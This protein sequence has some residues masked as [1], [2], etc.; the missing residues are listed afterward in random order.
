MELQET[1]IGV[2]PHSSGMPCPVCMY[3][4]AYHM[5]VCIHMPMC[6]SIFA[7]M[8]IAS[9]GVPAYPA[10]SSTRSV[11][12]FCQLRY[13]WNRW[14]TPLGDKGRAWLAKHCDDQTATAVPRVHPAGAFPVAWN[15]GGV[16]PFP[17]PLPPPESHPFP[18]AWGV[19]PHAM[20]HMGIVIRPPLFE[21]TSLVP[22]PP[23]YP[24]WERPNVTQARQIAMNFQNMQE[25]F[26]AMN[27]RMDVIATADSRPTS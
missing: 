4:C 3:M 13:S 18:N 5:Y 26:D 24:P 19:Q 17:P 21:G 9:Q 16:H 11:C 23:N 6:I 7:C 10:H 1:Y 25:Q 8:W 27:R 14:G 15:A 12:R 22:R 2:C 20:P